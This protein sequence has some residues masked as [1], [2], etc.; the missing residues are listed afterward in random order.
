MGNYP[1][2]KVLFLKIVLGKHL[3]SYWNSKTKLKKGKNL[4]FKEF[5]NQ[6][7]KYKLLSK[8]IEI[9]LITCMLFSSMMGLQMAVTIIVSF[10]TR[11]RN[12]G[13][14]LTITLSKWKVKKLLCKNLSVD[15]QIQTKRLTCQYTR[16]NLY[17]PGRIVILAAKIQW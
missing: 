9:C 8:I 7:K 6:K 13:G 5:H 14:V 15:Q 12:V 2:L 11:L 10:L 17:K 3:L 4:S 1:N 16:I